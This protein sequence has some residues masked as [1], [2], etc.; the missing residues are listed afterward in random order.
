MGKKALPG[1]PSAH[2]SQREKFSRTVLLQDEEETT[3]QIS[4]KWS[5]L[6]SWVENRKG[7]KLVNR[8]SA[9]WERRAS[10]NENQHPPGVGGG[11]SDTLKERRRTRKSMLYCQAAAVQCGVARLLD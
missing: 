1:K 7:E 2:L 4:W 6:Q 3:G 11:T 9:V 8:V 10:K 5:E